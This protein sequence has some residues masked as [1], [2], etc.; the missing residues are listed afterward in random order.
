MLSKMDR[1]ESILYYGQDYVTTV[2]N[3]IPRAPAKSARDTTTPRSKQGWDD[4]LTNFTCTISFQS[5]T[6]NAGSTSV[7]EDGLDQ[8]NQVVVIHGGDDRFMLQINCMLCGK[9]EN[10]LVPFERPHKRAPQPS[11][12]VPVAITIRDRGNH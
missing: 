1:K 8:Y 11:T 4:G 3:V 2:T 6:D 10:V 5:S 9:E 7:E 12:G